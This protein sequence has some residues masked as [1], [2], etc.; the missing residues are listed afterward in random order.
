M[1]SKP[2]HEMAT[3]FIDVLLIFSVFMPDLTPANPD[4]RRLYDDLMTGYNRLVRPV[5]NTS[6]TLTVSLGLRLSQLIDVVSTHFFFKLSCPRTIGAPFFFFSIAYNITIFFG[7]RLTS[8]FCLNF[9][10]F[11]YSRRQLLRSF[12][13][14]N[15]R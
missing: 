9:Q 15:F 2:T 8:F 13:D 5:S 6:D 1:L 10:K 12:W 14:R 3:K 11:K 4:A 7:P